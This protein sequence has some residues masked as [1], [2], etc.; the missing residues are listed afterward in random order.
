[1]CVLIEAANMDRSV[2]MNKIAT[3]IKPRSF[4]KIVNH[5][6][7]IVDSRI[8]QICKSICESLLS[9]N[10]WVYLLVKSKWTL[11]KLTNYFLLEDQ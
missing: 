5:I 4:A 1:M 2:K 8:L 9:V 7:Q 11:T 6:Q 3:S 10:L